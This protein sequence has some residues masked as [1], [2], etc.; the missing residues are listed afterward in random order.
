VAA[1]VIEDLVSR[2]WL[3][4]IVSAEETSTQVEV[5]FTGALERKGL[6]ERVTA[7][8]GSPGRPGRP[9]RG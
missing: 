4:K 6:L 1:T 7:R 8:Q 3:A 9:D 5:V 2:K